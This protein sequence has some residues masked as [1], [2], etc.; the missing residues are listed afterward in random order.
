MDTDKNWVDWKTY[1]AYAQFSLASLTGTNNNSPTSM[2]YTCIHEGV[3]IA[4]YCRFKGLCEISTTGQLTTLLNKINYNSNRSAHV[5]LVKAREGDTISASFYSSY[6]A[7]GSGFTNYLAIYYIGNGIT[8]G[9]I[10]ES[11]YGID[12]S[13]SITTNLPNCAIISC[14]TGYSTRNVDISGDIIRDSYTNGVNYG[15]ITNL[16]ESGTISININ[17]IGYGGYI[18][19]NIQFY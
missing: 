11:Y 8:G 18:I 4:A 2:S 16:Y 10:V 1:D 17:A 7:G 19:A 13:K 3:Y 12:G 5:V 14:G 6:D 9:T 15:C